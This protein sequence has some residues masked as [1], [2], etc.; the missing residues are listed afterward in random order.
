[1]IE[2]LVARY[3]EFVLLK[4][5]FEARTLLLWA[6]PPAVLIFGGLALFV[7]ARGGARRQRPSRS[8]TRRNA[9]S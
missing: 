9:A 7:L 6:V 2:F 5:R 1:M 4:P 3:G 8:L